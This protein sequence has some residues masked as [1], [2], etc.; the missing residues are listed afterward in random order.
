ML[1]CEGV[2]CLKMHQRR[3]RVF[4]DFDKSLTDMVREDILESSKDEEIDAEN[5]NL[6]NEAVIF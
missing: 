6:R 4:N 2:K 1:L 5:E 3:C